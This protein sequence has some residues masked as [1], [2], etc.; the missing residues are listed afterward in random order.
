MRPRDEAAEIDGT[1]DLPSNM[2]INPDDLEV[3][4]VDAGVEEEGGAADEPTLGGLGRR[5]CVVDL[6]PFAFGK[7]Y[8]KALIEG[9]APNETISHLVILTTSAHPAPALAGHENSMNVHILLDRVKEHSRRHGQQIM[10]SWF[11][12]Q[13]VA[14]ERARADVTAKRLRVEDLFFVPVDAPVSQVVQFQEVLPNP[15]TS[16]WRAG[17]NVWPET[18]TLEQ[19]VMELVAQELVAHQLGVGERSG[20]RCLVTTR[21]IKDWQ[22]QLQ[23]QR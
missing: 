8:Y 5:D 4:G 6:W 11:M 14:I 22:P 9:L 10:K 3:M 21:A 2:E 18:D 7:D 19:G 15:G 16:G 23:V 13:F 12:K 20:K 1:A 17:F